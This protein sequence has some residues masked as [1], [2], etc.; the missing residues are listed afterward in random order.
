MKPFIFLMLFIFNMQPPRSYIHHGARRR[1][2]V[3][4]NFFALNLRDL[5]AL[6]GKRSFALNLRALRDLRGNALCS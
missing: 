4:I 3:I 1:H 5:R 2:K 6:R